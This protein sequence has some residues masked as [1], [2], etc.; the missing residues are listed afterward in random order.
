MKI[1][2]AV[3]LSLAVLLLSAGCSS[4]AGPSAA[5]G[6]GW[7]DEEVTFDADG[8]TVHG[9]FRHRAE[10]QAGP[11]A[12]LISESG[13]TD[14]NGDNKVAG[15][16][17]NMRQLAEL[18]SDRGVASLRYDKIG[19]GATGLG[20]FAKNPRD[21]VSAV[22]TSGAKAALRFL[23]GRPG[24][25]AA[26]LSVYAIGEGTIHALELADDTTPGAPKVHSLGLFQPLPGRYLDIITSRVEADGKP[27][28]VAAWRSAVEQIRTKGTV[29]N[30]LP[31]GLN[32]IVNPGNLAAVIETDRI[33]P[34]A[35]AAA[36][37][38]GTPVLLTCSDADNQARCPAVRPLADALKHTALTFV[39]LK[40]VSHVL[41]DDPTD[42]IA[43]YA[44]QDP[45]S[46][47][48]VSA[49]N[50]FVHR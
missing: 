11:A 12:L 14:R 3:V 4:E 49:L 39:E 13:N 50:A 26:R 35:L 24:A 30:T 34:L 1:L 33:D 31:D 32:S 46:P 48:V 6:T 36:V 5:P 15:P 23:A 29:P 22:Y 44:K 2:A 40:G 17:G 18:L 27:E 9:T 20:P 47:Q 42:S 45:L 10:A 43:N 28:T 19:T 37:P 38:A 16:I 8:L 25:D 7:T 41:R 21:V